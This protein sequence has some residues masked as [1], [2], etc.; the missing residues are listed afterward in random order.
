MESQEKNTK[1]KA[2]NKTQLSSAYNVG[3]QTLKKW[4]EPFENEI[5]V[6]R[7]RT[8]TPQQVKIIFELLGNP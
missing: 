4:L 8:Y 2:M 7:G 1:I 3:M 5:G 6:Y